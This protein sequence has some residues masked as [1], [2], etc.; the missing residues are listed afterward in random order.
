MHMFGNAQEARFLYAMRMSGILVAPSGYASQ[1]VQCGECL[2]KCPQLIEIPDFLEKVAEEMED[3]DL[4]KRVA[5]AKK[6]LN[7][8]EKPGE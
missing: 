1:C 2:D 5:M 6:M 4:E 8:G 3:A 7:L